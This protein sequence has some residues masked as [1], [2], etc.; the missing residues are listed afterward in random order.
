MALYFEK[1]TSLDFRMC[2]T[3]KS[4]QMDSKINFVCCVRVYPKPIKCNIY[5]SLSLAHKLHPTKNAEH[6]AQAQ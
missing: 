5:E 6:K 4:A 3:V 1:K 2:S